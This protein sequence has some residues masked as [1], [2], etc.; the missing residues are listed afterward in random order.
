MDATISGNTLAETDGLPAERRRW[1]ALTIFTALA[2][3][4][5]DTA[6]SNVGLPAIAADLHVSPAEVVWVV[7][8]YQIAMVTTLLPF[9]ALGDIVGLK[10]L[11]LIGLV[12]FTAGS[13]T[14]SF[15]TSLPALL[16]ARAAEGLGASAMMSINTALVRFIYPR[17]LLGQGFGWNALVVAIGFSV[18][19]LVAAGVLSMAHWPW[20]YR[21]N[22]PFGI[23]A[24]FIAIRTLPEPPRGSHAFDLVAA[25]MASA[26]LGL[27]IYG[28][29]SLGHGANPLVVIAMLIAALVIGALLMRRHAD[30]PAPM[31]PVD[32]FRRP[33]F[34]LSAATAF[35]AFATQQFGLV[36]LPFLFEHTLGLSAVATGLLITPWSVVVGIMAPVAGRLS[37]RIPV[38]LLG[39][40]GL[41]ILA[42]GMILLATLPAHPAIADIV[43]RMMV[44]G[45]GFGFYQA[46]NMRALMGSAPPERSGGASGMVATARLTGQTSGATLTALCFAGAGING[47]TYALALGAVFAAV[48]A[49]VSFTRLAAE[50]GR[51]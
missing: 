22:V 18:G 44:C 1:A 49:V 16:V 47:P 14:C 28:L 8:I 51:G 23:A 34:A 26:C 11:Y 50:P 35:F 33:M 38:G 42:I 29:G 25:V 32:L 9:A 10:R 46:P 17:R 13:L 20:L 31:L 24:V 5:L 4:S 2:M 21:I 40:A 6:I 45:F 3:A 43:W 48:G 7:N 36:S 12:L 39:G 30:H 37:N 19:P 41:I 15:A 27:F